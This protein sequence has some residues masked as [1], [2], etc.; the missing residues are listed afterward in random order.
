MEGVEVAGVG[1]DDEV[2]AGAGFDLEAE[3]LGAGE[4]GDDPDVGGGALEGVGGLGEGFAEGGSGEDVKVMGGGGVTGGEEEECEEG[5]GGEVCARKSFSQKTLEVR[6]RAFGAGLG[7]HIGMATRQSNAVVK[8]GLRG[9]CSAGGRAC[10]RRR[11]MNVEG[12]GARRRGGSVG[13]TRARPSVGSRA[14]GCSPWISGR[15]R[16]GLARGG[17]RTFPQKD[18]AEPAKD[19]ADCS[20]QRHPQLRLRRQQEHCTLYVH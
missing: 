11:L 3:E 6:G 19:E 20:G 5:L 7:L 10:A 14:S 1:G 15:H 17:G 18:P 13:D 2:G 16:D 12:G 4:V 8:R 9:G